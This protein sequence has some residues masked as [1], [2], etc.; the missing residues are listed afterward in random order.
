M[1]ESGGDIFEKQPYPVVGNIRCITN[2]QE[3][4]LG[5]FQV[6]AAKSVEMHISHSEINELDIPS[7]EYPCEIIPVLRENMYDLSY[8][9][10][11]NK[12]YLFYKYDEFFT[13][14]G[15]SFFAFLFTEAECADCSLTG[16][17]K[18]PG[19]WVDLE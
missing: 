13:W 15:S 14:D 16:N 12:G 6:S 2:E 1:T 4:V 11:L 3:K 7:Y 9:V 17:P 10:L 18:R 8:R 19:F 5:N